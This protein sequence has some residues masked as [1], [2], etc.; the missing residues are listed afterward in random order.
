MKIN[1][2]KSKGFIKDTQI[3]LEKA[4]RDPLMQE[5]FEGQKKLFKQTLNKAIARAEKKF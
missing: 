5:Y 2:K 4:W 3:V 1:Q